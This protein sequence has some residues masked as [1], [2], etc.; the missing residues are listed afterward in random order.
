MFSL[1]CGTRLRPWTA[2]HAQI[3]L[4]CQPPVQQ[5]H[6]VNS[7]IVQFRQKLLGYMY[8]LFPKEFLWHGQFIWVCC[9]LKTFG[10]QFKRW[11]LVSSV[12]KL[13]V[14][15]TLTFWFLL[16]M[17]GLHCVVWPL[18][19]CSWNLFQMMGCDT[20][21]RAPWISLAVLVLSE[22]TVC[23][24][25]KKIPQSRHLRIILMHIKIWNNYIC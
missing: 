16:L 21:T 12:L 1:Q 23:L 5:Q 13:F 19:F 6:H 18:Y 8:L 11:I 4:K 24:T 22:G 14:N 3:K 9:T 20:L 7:E 2:S 25:E 10:F 15:S 17:R